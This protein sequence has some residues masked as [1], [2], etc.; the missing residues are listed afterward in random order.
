MRL[1][2]LVIVS[3]ALTSI[4][5]SQP[6]KDDVVGFWYTQDKEAKMQTYKCGDRY[7]GK[8]IWLKDPLEEDGSIKLDKENPD[9]KIRNR[10]IVGLKIMNGFEYDDNEWENGKIYDP[11]SGSTYSCT[12]ELSD[13]KKKLKVRGYIGI[14]LFGRTEIWTRISK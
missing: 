14:S 9:P 8:I 3:C 10:K 1:F 6:K 4:C 2:A 11:K 5:F 13:D 12:L 7:C